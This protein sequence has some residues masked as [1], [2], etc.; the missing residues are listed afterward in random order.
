MACSQRPRCSCTQSGVAARV[1]ELHASRNRVAVLFQL[2][3]I[4]EGW[5]PR[6]LRVYHHMTRGNGMCRCGIRPG[7][8]RLARLA[9]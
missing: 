4:Q 1:L 2:N 3:S 5:R 6:M 7:C 8:Q 9:S